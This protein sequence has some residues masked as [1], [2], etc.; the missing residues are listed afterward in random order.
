VTELL[1][2]NQSLR[3]E[4]DILSR[5][6]EQKD[7]ELYGLNSE[8]GKLRERIEV[9]ETLVRATGKEINCDDDLED[10]VA[11]RQL[12][13]VHDSEVSRRGS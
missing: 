3:E 10:A 9:L 2:A 6:M 7:Y 4:V 5:G 1:R 8:N 11:L 13:S 12:Q